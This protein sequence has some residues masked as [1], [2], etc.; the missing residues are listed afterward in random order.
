MEKALEKIPLVYDQHIYFE[1][2]DLRK[3]A[4]VV[5]ADKLISDPGKTYYGDS[6]A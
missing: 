2:G 3:L 4:E 5:D 1:V 6:N